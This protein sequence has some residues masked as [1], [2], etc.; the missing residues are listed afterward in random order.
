VREGA[1]EVCFE[2]DDAW[3]DAGIVDSRR[4]SFFLLS[5][6][7]P[8]RLNARKIGVD[9]SRPCL[10]HGGPRSS[11]PSSPGTCLPLRAERHGGAVDF[12]PEGVRK[13]MGSA[14]RGPPT[15]GQ[16]PA[17]SATGTFGGPR[18]R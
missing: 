7:G 14:G 15:P 18:G 8:Y 12:L 9:P 13:G 17:T 10:V 1:W 5:R 2:A 3:N 4:S 6:C 16:P 11:T